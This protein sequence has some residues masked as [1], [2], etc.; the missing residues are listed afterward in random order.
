LRGCSACLCEWSWEMIVQSFLRDIRARVH[1]FYRLPPPTRHTPQNTRETIP[2]ATQIVP[3][4]QI[5][6]E[7]RLCQ[8]VRNH[9]A[10]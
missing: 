7:N 10:D 5:V 3:E 1:T 2:T 8:R 6:P 9:F 4:G